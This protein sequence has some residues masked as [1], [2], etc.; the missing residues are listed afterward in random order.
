[1]ELLNQ[2]KESTLKFTEGLF[3][4]FS[5]GFALLLIGALFITTPNLYDSTI[6][7]LQDLGLI[8]VPNTDIIFLGPEHQ[9]MHMT[10]YQA[11]GQLSIAVAVFEVIMLALRFVFPSSW[12]KRSETAGNLVYWAGAA[13]LAQAFLIDT[14]QWFVYWSAI[15]IVIGVSL[16]A[17]AAVNAISKM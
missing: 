12:Q 7:F 1:M 2:N 17:R 15:I 5:V 16:L 6:D 14:Q 9:G 3:T 11:V 8:D 10:V 4:A 13:F